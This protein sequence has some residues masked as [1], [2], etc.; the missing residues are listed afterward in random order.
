MI[1]RM[2]ARMRF[3]VRIRLPYDVV[4]STSLIYDEIVTKIARNELFLILICILAKKG[5]FE[6]HI[7]VIYCS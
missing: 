5:R 3:H 7:H 6:K 4:L 2:K 1:V